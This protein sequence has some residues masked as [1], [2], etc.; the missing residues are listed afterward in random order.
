M[1]SLTKKKIAVAG[2][3]ALALVGGSVTAA[4]AA[5]T[6]S[7]SSETMWLWDGT[8]GAEK[9]L[10]PT[11]RVM[12]WDEPVYAHPNDTDYA[13]YSTY[14]RGPSNA[15]AVSIFLSNR[16]E[17]MT[18]S[19]WIS[20]G[21]NAFSDPAA[22]TVLAPQVTLINTAGVN[23]AAAKA[24]G[25]NFSLGI[26]YTDINGVAVRAVS[27]V[28]IT[29]RPGGDWTYEATTD[30]TTTNPPAGSSSGSVD[31]EATTV[32]AQDGALSLTVP[33]GAK[34][35]FSAA[36]LV[37]GKSTSTATLPEVTVTDD[38]IVSKKGWTVT[39]SVADFV[40]GT[41]VIGAKNLG[42]APKVIAAG[43]TSTGVAAASAQVAGSA[44]YSSP[45]ADAPAG[46]GVGVTKL[47]AD[48][49][50]VAPVDAPAGTYTSKMTLTL[51]SK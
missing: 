5:I 6:P 34:A 43:T 32:A 10:A 49:T 14:F 40:N 24:N 11:T 41:N 47:G 51:V 7:G 46:S 13:T 20:K 39:Q 2:V 37:G 29:I 35:V 22:K 44:I 17:E 3:L 27:F 45:F 31:L 48:L 21:T 4:A 25:G 9:L 15:Q 12:A 36:T 8:D 38:R 16:G 30:Q 18:S 26:A 23:L 42:V 33:A 1:F 19:S 50:L 28:H